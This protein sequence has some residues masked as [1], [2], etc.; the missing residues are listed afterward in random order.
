LFATKG[1]MAPAQLSASR[2]KL[3]QRGFFVALQ[4]KRRGNVL[5]WE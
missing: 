1:Q 3:H 5:L 4:M 2:K